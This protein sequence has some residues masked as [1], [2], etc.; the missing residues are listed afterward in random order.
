MTTRA[1][2]I[3]DILTNRKP[4]AE[5]TLKT[6][7]LLQQLQGCLSRFSDFLTGV[8][9][10]VG[11]EY[12]EKIDRLQG[13]LAKLTSEQIL[14]RVREL[15]QLYSRFNRSTLNIG[16][17]GNAGQG[18]STLLQQLTGL[19]DDEI[20]TG[21]KG[22]CTGAAAIIENAPVPEA[23]AD[24][25]FHTVQDFLSQIVAPY[26]K[27][28]ELPLPSTLSDFAKPLPEEAK[29]EKYYDEVKF[30]ERLQSELNSYKHFLG[31]STKRIPK[32][33]IRTYTAK[34]DK[35]GKP[36]S[37]WAAVKSAKVFCR[38][39]GLE[40]EK[41]SVGD[42]PGLGDRAV[43]EAEEQLMKDFGRNIDAVVMMRKVNIRGIRKEDVRLFNLVKEAIPELTAEQWSYFMVNVFA[44]DRQNEAT[45]EALKFLPEDFRNSSLKDIQ[46]FIEV[47]CSDREAVLKEFDGILD[48]IAAN[49]QALD[50]TLY[51]KRMANVKSLLDEVGAFIK[52]AKSALPKNV[53]G[54][55]NF[56]QLQP[57]FEKCWKQITY[58]LGL[59]VNQ[60]KRNV[61]DPDTRL[62]DE[63][64][65]IKKE[66]E[67]YLKERLDKVTPQDIAG[68]GGLP[69][70][71]PQ[72]MGE[73]R[74]SLS[75][76][77]VQLDGLFMKDFEAIR[78]QA[79]EVLIAPDKG[80][81]G[82][83]IETT[84][85]TEW[86][87]ELSQRL[88]NLET[89]I[90]D[91]TKIADAIAFFA[92]TSF[93]FSSY[94]LP[95]VR[96]KLNVL[97]PNDPASKPFGYEAGNEWDD[98]RENLEMAFE[99]A[100][101]EIA[102][103]LK[104]LSVDVSKAKYAMIEQFNDGVTFS[105]SFETAKNLWYH[106]YSENRAE[107]WSELFA[108]LEENTKLRNDWNRHLSDIESGTRQ[109]IG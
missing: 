55:A 89:K 81:L 99:K 61:D 83:I 67:Q 4:I 102:S 97:D 20:P 98:V 16:V 18:K 30:V 66:Q 63:V 9:E 70:F 27:T 14:E 10:K 12:L 80:K 39:P 26:Y 94:L 88:R 101:S 54:N 36:L 95:R 32:E 40:D 34:S 57:E 78:K 52:E 77:F 108:Q 17:V 21:A 33:E 5:K 64:G 91:P 75:N 60:Y 48:N 90:D 44:S 35:D 65:R 103:A 84:D 79:Y 93:R 82:T 43:L 50:N 38:F 74:I 104:K 19:A 11:G 15:N 109:V 68:A 47:D 29:K 51:E 72:M 76:A 86:F 92:E 58:E 6:T 23:Y 42:T 73:L 28:L 107:V 46:K 69:S 3:N 37:T 22:D 1:Q 56:G 45:V 7:E 59:L 41:I 2:K 85:P 87:N 25:E 53:G 24:I 100:V 8:K 105:G 106:F 71:S 13:E 96:E 49:Q 62:Q 31:Q